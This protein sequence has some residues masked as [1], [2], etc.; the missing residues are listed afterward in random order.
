MEKIKNLIDEL[1]RENYSKYKVDL[2]FYVP[3]KDDKF[4]DYEKFDLKQK[5]VFRLSPKKTDEALKR[6]D[7]CLIAKKLFTFI[8]EESFAQVFKYFSDIVDAPIEIDIFAK[9]HLPIDKFIPIPSL[10]TLLDK[11]SET[12]GTPLLTGLELHLTRQKKI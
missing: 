8:S 2:R 6:V 9:V 7:V 3:F 5:R 4:V 10:P 1:K 11:D 12:F